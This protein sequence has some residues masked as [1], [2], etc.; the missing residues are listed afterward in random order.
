MLQGPSSRFWPELGDELARRGAKVHKVNVHLGEV[1]YWGLRR[2]RCYWGRFSAWRSFLRH[3]LVKNGID[4]ILYYAD[5]QPY[6]VVAG[7]LAVELGLQAYVIENGYLRPDWITFEPLGM[8]R[9]SHFLRDPGVIEKIAAQSPDPD[10]HVRYSFTFAEEAANEVAFNLLGY[11][12]RIV[13]PFYRSDKYYSPL[14]DYLFNL[15]RQFRLKGLNERASQEMKVITSRGD[16]FFLVALQTQGDYQIRDNSPYMH[17]RE[18]VFEVLQSF[19]KSAEPD[20]RLVFK[21]HPHDNGI[22]GW[23]D[24]VACYA[25]SLGIRD[26][27]SVIDGGHL[28]GILTSAQGTILINSTVALHAL[29]SRCPVKVMGS[30]ICDVPG[31]TFDGDLDSFWTEVQ[32]VNEIFMQTFVKVLAYAVQVKGSFYNKSGRVAAT[33]EIAQRLSRVPP[34]PCWIDR[35]LRRDRAESVSNLQ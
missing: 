21:I 18:M 30:T 17:I 34:G 27:V 5:R 19:K 20:T 13:F 16:R 12:G 14:K 2:S 15:R 7:E 3:Y 4:T 28:Q 33:V 32:P 25:E 6:H 29:R 22:E 1:A 24:L 31:L 11:F 23:G 10:L 9:F 8:S 35:S 26:R